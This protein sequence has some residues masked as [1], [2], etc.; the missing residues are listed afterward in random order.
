MGVAKLKYS[1]QE[2]T[3]AHGVIGTYSYMAPEM[4]GTARRGIEV[5]IYSLGC[6][7]IELFGESRVWPDLSSGIENMHKVCGS[8][9]TPPMMPKTDHLPLLYKN[10]CDGCCQ[11]KPGER[12]NIK[13][14]CEKLRF[15]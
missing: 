12:I 7:Y 8:F 4:F 11:L 13:T 15:V 6:L 5:D 1:S 9:G 14:V 2:M 3:T 10:I